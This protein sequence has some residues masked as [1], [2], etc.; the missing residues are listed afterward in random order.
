MNQS[1]IEAITSQVRE[2]V[3]EQVTIGFRLNTSD[4]LRKQREIFLTKQRAK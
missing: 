2:N 4:W 1:E 3:C